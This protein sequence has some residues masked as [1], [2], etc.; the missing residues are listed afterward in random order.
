MILNALY[1]LYNRL[2]K[3][4]NYKIAPEGY[5]LQKISFRVVLHQNGDLFEI[6]D[7]RIQKDK[8]Q[9]PKIM[10]VPGNSKSSGSGI[11]PC[12]L[13][14]NTGYLL[15]YKTDD[16]KPERTQ[17]TFEGFREKHLQ[18][19]SE[20]DSDAFRA[21][22][23]FLRT[24]NPKNAEIYPVLKNIKNGYGVFQIL[25]TIDYVHTDHA[26]VNWW[27]TQLSED[28]ATSSINGQCL[29]TGEFGPISRL[30]EPQIKGVR[31]GKSQALLVSFNDDAYKSYGQ[32]QSYNAPVSISA[33]FKYA[34]ALNAL[35]D[36]PM[37]D[38][39]SFH[40]GDA[41]ILFWTEEKTE[42]E[43]VFAE[44]MKK[45]DG[46]VSNETESQDPQNLKKLH[47]FLSSIQK[48]QKSSIDSNITG[49]HMLGLS[50]NAGRI[51]VRFYHH[52]KLGVLIENLH[53]HLIDSDVELA[54]F[55]L[56][57]NNR[58]QQYPPIW[59]LLAQTVRETS[60]KNKPEVS[61]FIAGALLR[62]IIIG[63]P[64]PTSLYSTIIRRISIDK[65]NHQKAYIIK[66][67]LNRNLQK[68]ITMSLDT[69]RKD[70][71]YRLGRLFAS[72]EKTQEE[73]NPEN[74][75]TIRDQF[76][77][78]ASTT[79]A[80]VFPRLLRLYQHHLSKLPNPGQKVNREKLL[81]EIMEDMCEFPKSL[82]LT[83]QG[84]FAL[85]YYHQKNNFYRSR[86]NNDVN[87]QND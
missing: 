44:Y 41:T 25:N 84:L 73:A 87:P 65:I 70:P 86:K 18:L 31:G 15:G 40:L 19:E 35:L 6:Q 4:E 82:N 56:G 76:Y 36:G 17:L 43:D 79:P 13:W 58:Q 33:T 53:K 59:D 23:Q 45:S 81:Q 71:A 8:S 54:L 32:D 27:S 42:E 14:D 85:G 39:H 62:S 9:I 50:P 77:S 30:H 37:R 67:Y 60:G 49:F 74:K 72:L 48:G 47:D 20:I 78:S 1:Q 16:D 12:F 66:G 83:D 38:K 68:G 57:K 46:I 5:S 55:P 52:D 22:C 51:S 29:I 2:I 80:T 3:E 11:N 61:P 64:Y 34:T 28:L 7:L 75:K 21:V 10:L 63:T 24:W 26:V 69:K